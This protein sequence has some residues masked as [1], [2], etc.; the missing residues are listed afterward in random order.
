MDIEASIAIIVAS[1]ALIGTII[2]YLGGAKKN[3]VEA[4]RGII[5][6]LKDYVEQL[7]YDKEDLQDWAERLVCQVQ[8]AGLEPERFYKNG[9]RNGNGKPG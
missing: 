9:K 5:R 8:A 1:L 6:E 2:T 4:L 7:E 3:E